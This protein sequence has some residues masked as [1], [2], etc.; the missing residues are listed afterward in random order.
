MDEEKEVKRKSEQQ[1]WK[2]ESNIYIMKQREV[3][4]HTY[5]I[6]FN[7]ISSR[8]L[9]SSNMLSVLIGTLFII[10]SIALLVEWL[11]HYNSEKCMSS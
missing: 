4:T 11:H 6:E 3:Q 1:T 7:I 2:V 10:F 5:K 9:T 8:N